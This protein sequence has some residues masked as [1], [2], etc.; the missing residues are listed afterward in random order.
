MVPADI[1]GG[2]IRPAR[3][4]LPC[5]APGRRGAC[6]GSILYRAGASPA[7]GR[8]LC[9]HPEK[10]EER[11]WKGTYGYD[12]KQKLVVHCSS[13]DHVDLFRGRCVNLWGGWKLLQIPS[14]LMPTSQAF[15]IDNPRSVIYRVTRIPCNSLVVPLDPYIFD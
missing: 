6:A 1:A 11:A 4:A 2:G 15:I 3:A 10:P 8:V 5:A 7:F 14:D 12:P 13:R 9:L